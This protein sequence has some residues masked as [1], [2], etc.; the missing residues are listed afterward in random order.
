MTL[1]IK[2]DCDMAVRIVLLGF[3]F[4]SNKRLF[5]L[6]LLTDQPQ[7]YRHPGLRA[8]H[9]A[10]GPFHDL[11]IRCVRS[12]IFTDEELVIEDESHLMLVEMKFVFTH[13]AFFLENV[14][15]STHKAC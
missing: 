3:L 12:T 9:D 7:R 8:T 10:L 5:I 4:A 1:A 14:I 15:S 13:L 2:K 6:V 11:L